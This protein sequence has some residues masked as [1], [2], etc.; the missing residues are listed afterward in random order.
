MI[1]FGITGH[2][3]LIGSQIIKS[4]K[5]FKFIKFNGDIRDKKDIIKWI[6]KKNIDAILHLA[7]VV[8]A[9]FRNKD[10]K[11]VKEINYI[12]TKNL[13]DTIIKEQ[14]KLKWFFFSSSSHVYKFYNKKILLNEN[15]FSKPFSKYGYTKLLAEKYI[16]KQCNKFK[17]PYCIGRIFSILDAK[18]PKTFFFS[19][20]LKKVKK[21]KKIIFFENLCHSRDFLT[22]NDII[23]A[24][25]H[26]YNKKCV[27]IF[28]IAS[29]RELSL[30]TIVN[31]LCKIFKKRAKIKF[32]SK[33]TYAIADIK[34]IKK[35]GWLPDKKLDI[36]KIIFK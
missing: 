26:L 15:S 29:G 1:K 17:I 30:I 25:F 23:N 2:T 34:K 22:V 7:A 33:M 19:N 31:Q 27:G 20:A 14:I 12:G 16:V 3:G 21:G 6:K 32:K 24:I 13:I 28:N 4:K 9:K 35:T 36:A 11:K 8:P 18:Q 10:F 5:K